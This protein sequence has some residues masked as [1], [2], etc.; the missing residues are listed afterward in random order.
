MKIKLN[1]DREEAQLKTG[2][3]SLEA[4]NVQVSITSWNSGLCFEFSGFLILSQDLKEKM[5]RC[6][7]IPTYTH[8]HPH[9]LHVTMEAKLCLEF[10]V[11]SKRMVVITESDE[12]SSLFSTSR[13]SQQCV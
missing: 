7:H 11:E 13:G 8:M 1:A 3:K 4:T 12:W 5:K 9:L 2:S 6:T 10:E